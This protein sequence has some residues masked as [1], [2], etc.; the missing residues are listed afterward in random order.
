MEDLF[1]FFFLTAEWRE[2]AAA[3]LSRYHYFPARPFQGEGVDCG[4]A[5]AAAAADGGLDQFAAV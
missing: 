3:A 2:Y 4:G 5:A 1:L